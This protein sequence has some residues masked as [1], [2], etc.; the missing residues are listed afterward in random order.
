M[1]VA[2][3]LGVG[4]RAGA[5][6]GRASG[7]SADG[8]SRRGDEQ[9]RTAEAPGHPAL[10]EVTREARRAPRRGARRRRLLVRP[11]VPAARRRRAPA[12]PLRE[13]NETSSVADL[14]WW[15]LFKDPVLQAL[16]REALA[17]NQDLALAVARVDEARLRR[18]AS[19]RPT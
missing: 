5:V 16:I 9:R 17:A 13:A 8:A 19:R 1:L 4:A 3:I 2:T 11:G 12:V 10:R 14:P 18:R 7:S 6:R 15:E